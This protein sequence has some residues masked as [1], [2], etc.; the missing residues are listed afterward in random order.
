LNLSTLDVLHGELVRNPDSAAIPRSL[1]MAQIL[2]VADF[3]P[4]LLVGMSDGIVLTFTVDKSDYSLSGKKSIVLGTQQPNFRVLAGADGLSNIFTTC[5]H[6]SLIYS[7]EGRIVYSAVTAEDATC[8]CSFDS[9]AYPDSIILATSE[10][11]R[12]AQVDAERRT[13]V[14]T[15]EVGEAVRRIAYSASEG[16]FGMGCIK[17]VLENGEEIVSS[18]FRLVDEVV[19]GKLGK[20]YELEI[21]EGTELVESVIRAQ[22]PNSYGELQERF[23]VGTSFLEEDID[24]RGRIIVFGIDHDRS[25]YE[26]MS[27]KLKGACRCLGVLDGKIVAALV[28]TVVMFEY[29]EETSTDATLERVASYRTSTMPIDIAIEGNIIAVADLMKSVSL[30]EWQAGKDGVPGEMVEVSRHY[31]AHQTTAVCHIEGDTYLEADADGNLLVLR[32]NVEGITRTERLRLQ[33]TSE[34]NLGEQVNSIKKITVETSPNAPV[35]PRAFVATVSK[36]NGS[37]S[38]KTLTNKVAG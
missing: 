10:D 21:D 15:L 23:I 35:I 1:V 26:I 25:P 32:R 4:T 16:V 5:E 27:K 22:L 8:V 3:G 29:K 33:V 37:I 31:E 34:M 24:I 20:T 17:K 14:R 28:K 9:E 38:L 2:P 18:S 7:S 30:V 19:F 13:H 12:I 6:S 11:I 36:I